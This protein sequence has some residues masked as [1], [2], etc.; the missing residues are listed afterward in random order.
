[1]FTKS[2]LEMHSCHVQFHQITINIDLFEN[3]SDLQRID[4]NTKNVL[5]I[6]HLVNKISWKDFCMYV[7][8]YLNNK[9]NIAKRLWGEMPIKISLNLEHF[10]D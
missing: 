5:G 3:I 10:L 6:I 7:F 4:I 2:N 8:Y 1:M 9:C